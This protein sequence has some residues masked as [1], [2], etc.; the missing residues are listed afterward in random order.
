MFEAVSA[1]P[2]GVEFMTY[3]IFTPQLVKDTRIY[4][5][6]HIIHNWSNGDWYHVSRTSRAATKGT[7]Q[8]QTAFG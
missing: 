4:H 3:D 1:P 8:K 6:R 5:Y 2:D 7:A